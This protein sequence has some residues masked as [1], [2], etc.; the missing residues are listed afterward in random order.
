MDFRSAIL[1][2]YKLVPPSLSLSRIWRLGFAAVFL[3]CLPGQLKAQTRID[4]RVQDQKGQPIP[5]ANVSLKGTYDGGS[6]DADGLFS[7]ESDEEGRHLLTA[8]F[9]G[10][11]G[12]TDSVTLDGQALNLTIVLKEEFNELKAVVISAGSFEASDEGKAVVFKPLDIV[13]TAGAAGDLFGALGTLPGAQQVGNEEGLFVRGGAGYET[14]TIID[15]LPVLNPFF[16]QVPDVPSRGRFSPFLFKG[17]VFS[18]GGYSA[19]YGQALSSAVILQTNDMPSTS[20]SGLN[21]SP[22]FGGFFTQQVWDKTGFA[23]GAQYTNTWLFNELVPQEIEWTK[24]FQGLSGN[25]SFLHKTSKT[26]LLKVYATYSDASLGIR[27]PTPIP[28]LSGVDFSLDNQNVYVNTS[29]REILGKKWTL[30]A[31]AA[32][33]YNTDAILI[34]NV[35][36]SR[37]D[38][39]LQGRVALSRPLGD[40]VQIRTGG[41]YSW[42]RYENR[43]QL[44][45][46][47]QAFDSELDEQYGA[48]FVESEF[49]LSKSLAGRAGLRSE[50]S[51][52]LNQFNLAPRLSLA[53]KTGE[54][55]Q[56]SLAY[57]R[58]YQTPRPQFLGLGTDELRFERADHYIA[59]WQWMSPDRTFRLEGY[60]KRYD[61]L[62]TQ[63]ALDSSGTVLSY[64][65]LGDGYAGGFELFYR[66]K[67]SI[68]NVDFWISY[69]W[70]STERIF[71]DY[72]VRVRPDFAAEHVLS[73]VY[74]H[75]IPKIRSQV[76]ATYTFQ[77]PRPFHNPGDQEFM[78]ARAPA[79]HN[80]SMNWSYLT[81]IRGHFTIIFLSVTNL[82]GVDNIFGYRYFDPSGQP[83]PNYLFGLDASDYV[84]FAQRP[85]AIRSYFI[86]MFI[87]FQHSRKPKDLRAPSE[88]AKKQVEP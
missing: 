37:R 49:Y 87:S 55:S 68:D 15:G 27:Y 52:A 80:L 1:L 67:K 69:S 85:P 26:G 57:G 60:Y 53:Q 13:T 33:N 23:V 75:Y 42:Q 11:K 81:N 76:G 73:L 74:K 10:Y 88:R 65:S 9:I 78:A 46:L 41:E 32:G 59:N 63:D 36:N 24:D 62:V 56:V 6:S 58:F 35:D 3:M 47:D 16:S 40:Q 4:G 18:T 43:F 83:L 44:F 25:L 71:L 77:S 45:G 64:S 39:G 22:I 66:D 21:L 51:Q 72:P 82:P 54:N 31:T 79:F 28:G 17:T 50:Y 70:L 8:T 61:D 12:F 5:G 7:F 86:G 14:K 38:E 84:E 29:Y 30:L 19:Q 48:F 20:S 2:M 34:Q